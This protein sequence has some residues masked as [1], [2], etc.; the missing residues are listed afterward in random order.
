M[1]LFVWVVKECIKNSIT[2]TPARSH[3]YITSCIR[4]IFIK[5]VSGRN[6]EFI[7]VKRLRSFAR[8]R[9]ERGSDASPPACLPITPQSCPPQDTPASIRT[10]QADANSDPVT[11]PSGRHVSTPC[12][13]LPE[14]VFA[15][16]QLVVAHALTHEI[17]HRTHCA[18][19]L[20]GAADCLT[21]QTPFQTRDN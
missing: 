15:I 18:Q 14:S 9:R 3:S 20:T 21:S 5:T 10:P 6:D 13:S 12:S 19:W 1:Y 8:L 11:P 16:A 7:N 2:T 4:N 17:T